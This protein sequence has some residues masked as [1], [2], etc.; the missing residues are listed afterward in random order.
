MPSS[1]K[2]S[3]RTA[4]RLL[5]GDSAEAQA[6]RL[7][8]RLPADE[9]PRPRLPGMNEHSAEATL[10]RREVLSEQ[11]ISTQKIAAADGAIPSEMLSANIESHIGCVQIPVGVAGPLRINGT[12]AHGDF[13]VPLATNEGALVA[14]C[15]RGAYV[16]THAGGASTLCMTESVSR[17][18]CFMFESI[19]ESGQFL[20]WTLPQLDQLQDIV[21]QT[22]RFATL[23]DLRTTVL[24]KEVFLSFEYETGD[25]SGQNMVTLATDAICKHLVAH[26]PV[27]PSHWF[28]EGN[29][30]GDKKAT[31]L[32]F[33]CTRG[34]K[35]TAETRV[36]ARLLKRFTNATPE[37][38]VRYWEISFMG[39]SQSGSIGAQGHYAN[40]LAALFIACGQDAACVS[41]ASIGMTRM[42]IVG[43][44]D[45]YASVTL[46]NLIVGTVGGGTHL[47]AARECLEMLDSYGAGKARKF[48]EIC[49]ATVLAGEISII[50]AL[51]AGDFAQ[52]HARHGRKQS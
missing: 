29:M 48:A 36:P 18:P 44:G 46:P 49:A 43:D 39:G 37:Q 23:V 17:A 16:V 12:E 2:T 22:S 27:T 13:Y 50:A 7:A 19:A 40:P 31:M 10:R 6:K 45:L 11:G 20:S 34:K 33:L 15:N 51:A 52:A 24:G 47:P 28:V 3:S 14:S 4:E 21:R 41:E 9:R 32:S 5:G 25:A 35:V 42:D 30:S 1:Q 8:P 26:S 38:M